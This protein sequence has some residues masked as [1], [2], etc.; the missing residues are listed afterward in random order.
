M[1]LEVDKGSF[2]YREGD[3]PEEIYFLA[4]GKVNLIDP[5]GTIMLSMVEGCFFGEIEAIDQINR[6]Y[7][8]HAETSCSLYFCKSA[9]FIEVFN[10]YSQIKTEVMEIVKRR[11]E[12]YKLCKFLNNDLAQQDTANLEKIKFDK[13]KLIRSNQYYLNMLI[14][15]KEQQ[16]KKKTNG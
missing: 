3:Y 15:Y 16:I 1:Y 8:T 14:Q 7:F 13:E 4:Q 12:K 6:K 11:K 9:K 2:I 10:N 5:D